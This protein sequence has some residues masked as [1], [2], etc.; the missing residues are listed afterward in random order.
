L[1]WDD[2]DTPDWSFWRLVPT[3]TL[4][5]AVALSLNLDPRVLVPHPRGGR[6]A[7]LSVV[8][9]PPPE[10][11]FRLDLARRCINETL[12][13][14]KPRYGEEHVTLQC[15]TKWSIGFGWDIPPDLEALANV[16][17]LSDSIAKSELEQPTHIDIPG[18][19]SAG[20]TGTGAS[21]ELRRRARPQRDPFR[22]WYQQKYP[23]GITSDITIKN[24]AQEYHRDKGMSI[25]DSTI[26]RALGRKQ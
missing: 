23:N 26:R 25:S 6:P 2:D 9:I 11:Y 8:R 10:F 3:V 5:E 13:A 20:F 18:R 24:L 19:S 15:F 16:N 22:A 7:G 14:A 12:P 1:G 17:E 21:D 4:F